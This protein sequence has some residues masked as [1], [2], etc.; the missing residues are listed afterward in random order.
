[1]VLPVDPFAIAKGLGII[2]QAKSATTKGVSGMLV[3]HGDQFGI[4]Y[5]TH[6]ASEGFQRFSVSHELG[7]YLLPGHAEAVM[8][9]QNIHESRAE[10]VSNDRY[11]READHFAAGLLMPSLPFRKALKAAGEGLDAIETLANKCITSLTATAIRYAQFTEI[12]AAVIQSVGENI[13]WCFM[14]EAL[15]EIQGL[16]WINK[17]DFLPKNTATYTFNRDTSNVTGAQRMNSIGNLQDWFNGR[18]DT[19]VVEEVK[20]LGQ[21]GSTLTILTAENLDI[22]ELQENENL[23]EAWTPRFK[24]E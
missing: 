23:E 12:P 20:G 18:F 15:R 17:H 7:H 2:V 22:E 8:G 3:R 11:E 4:A 24:S 10:F 21:Y 9:S 5:A 13:K 16:D 1:M 19:E 14:S 6:I